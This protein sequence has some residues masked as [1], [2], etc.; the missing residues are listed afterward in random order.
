M[1]AELAHE[2]SLAAQSQEVVLHAVAADSAIL[3]AEPLAGGPEGG[4]CLGR[5]RRRR[6]TVVCQGRGRGREGPT[7]Q[8]FESFASRRSGVEAVLPTECAGP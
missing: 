7:E 2:R 8:L 6:R 1:S 5:C 4:S 3:G